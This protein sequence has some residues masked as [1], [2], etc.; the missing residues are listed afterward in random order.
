MSMKHIA[1]IVSCDL[2]LTCGYGYYKI[3]IQ[4]NKKIVFMRRLFD[5]TARVS[6]FIIYDVYPVSE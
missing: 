3:R 6:M 2:F 1:M 5:D 4:R